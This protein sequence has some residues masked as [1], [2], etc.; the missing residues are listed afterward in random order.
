MTLND[1]EGIIKELK[2]KDDSK[3]DLAVTLKERLLSDKITQYNSLQWALI[4]D[5]VEGGYYSDAVYQ[6]LQ[7]D[8]LSDICSNRLYSKIVDKAEQSDFKTKCKIHNFIVSI[9]EF[10]KKYDNKD[11]F[12]YYYDGSTDLTDII[13]R[14][15]V[16]STLSVNCPKCSPVIRV[17]MNYEEDTMYVYGH[18]NYDS[19]MVK[20]EILDKIKTTLWHV[21]FDILKEEKNPDDGTYVNNMQ[22]QYK[23]N[24]LC[25]LLREL[26]IDDLY[27]DI[28]EK[29]L[30]IFEF[31][32]D[33]G[34][35]NKQMVQM[36][37]KYPDNAIVS[38]ECCNVRNMNYDEKNNLITIN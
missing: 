29:Y 38:V 8:R 24:I 7:Y 19:N 22:I 32:S 18:K 34:I 31:K 3:Y 4:V 37:S 6:L 33:N 16:M 23:A 17:D 2:T 20:N 14:Y 35:T 30:N 25:N 15:Y 10:N 5:M 21:L 9:F 36:L 1:L 27:I 12:I 13:S 28:K 26:K 11:V